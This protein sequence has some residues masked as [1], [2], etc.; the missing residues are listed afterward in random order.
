M[1]GKDLLM[2]QRKR[3]NVKL[4]RSLYRAIDRGDW[5]T[6]RQLVDPNIEW[7]EPH[8]PGLWFSGRHC[9]IDNVFREVIDPARDKFDN[10][11]L[12][13]KKLFPI[14]QHVVAL[15][16]F[17]GYEKTEGLLLEAPTAHIWTLRDGKAIRF[18]AY[19]DVLEWHFALGVTSFQPKL[20]A[21]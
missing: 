20:M 5:A 8:A 2:K 9:G 13:I 18:E 1:N 15:G 16:V 7:N 4:I 17:H 6:A 14:G 12:K 10:L 21:A 11:H 3:E 19:D